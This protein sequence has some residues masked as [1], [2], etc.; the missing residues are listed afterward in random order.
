[1]SRHFRRTRGRL[2]G[3][4]VLRLGLERPRP[5]LRARIEDRVE[6][7]FAA[8]LVAEVE[9]LLAS[10]VPAEAPA[11]KGLGYRRV[12]AHLRG[13]A[14]LAEMILRTKIDTPHMPKRDDLVPE[15]AGGLASGR[16]PQLWRGRRLARDGR[17]GDGPMNAPKKSGPRQPAHGGKLDAADSMAELEAAR[18]AGPRSSMRPSDSARPRRFFIGPEGRGDPPRREEPGAGP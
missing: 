11:F 8:G 1:L 3:W 4:R 6:R 17:G 13:E 14:D 5:E 18:A 10:G 2:E 16:R 9:R 15:D 7:M 12:L